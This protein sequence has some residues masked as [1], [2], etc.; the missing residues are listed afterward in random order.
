MSTKCN[1]SYLRYLSLFA[2]S[3][4]SL[5]LFVFVLCLVSPMLPFSLDCPFFI[6]PSVFSNVYLNVLDQ[7]GF[8]KIIISNYWCNLFRLAVA[9]YPLHDFLKVILESWFYISL[10]FIR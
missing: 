8:R 3:G 10:T 2:Y 6:V 9:R 7:A 1:L 4:V 5:L